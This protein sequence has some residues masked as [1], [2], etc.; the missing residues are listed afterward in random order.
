ML[1]GRSDRAERFD[2]Q[3]V[4]EYL[5][6]LG[7]GG[8]ELLARVFTAGF[9]TAA[10]GGDLAA[11]SRFVLMQVVWNT[12]AAGFWNV[13]GGVDRLPEAVARSVPVEL[14]TE[15]HRVRATPGGVEVEASS[16]GSRRTVAARAAILAVPG[17]L[18]PE[19][20]P[21]APEWLRAPAGR[22]RFSRV[23]SAHVALRRPPDSPHAVLAFAGRTDG[24][25]VLE[26]E[27]LRAPGRCPDGTGMVSVY[28]ADVPG[29]ACL[30]ADDA[31][32]RARALETVARTFPGSA[33]DALFVHLIRWPA[34]IAFFPKGRLVEVLRLRSAL[35]Q[36]DTPIDVAGDWLDGVASE[37]A[38][39]MGEQA[40]DRVAAR[41]GRSWTVTGP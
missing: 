36:S 15:V 38:L 34:G 12:L 16:A 22:A 18:V 4:D 20:Y 32:L 24:V 14:G 9:L 37:S 19:L 28:F 31:T 40:A 1:H 21:D 5:S 17:H 7:A 13:A 25:G 26:L 11:C 35:A 23:A 27:H 33:A 41:L 8:R 29:F 2:R 10:L 39:Q 30:E 6:G 3:T